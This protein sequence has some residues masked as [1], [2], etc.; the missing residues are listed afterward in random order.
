MVIPYGR[1]AEFEQGGTM[2]QRG[3]RT[4]GL[5]K[6][7]ELNDP[8]VNGFSPLASITT[9]LFVTC[10]TVLGITHTTSMIQTFPK[11]PTG[12]TIGWNLLTEYAISSELPPVLLGA[13]RGVAA[14]AM[15]VATLSSRSWRE[16]RESSVRPGVPT[17]KKA[18]GRPLRADQRHVTASSALGTG[19]LSRGLLRCA[20][21]TSRAAQ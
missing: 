12:V 10:M 11:P 17:H 3:R 8:T 19:M 16:V 5:T 2:L 20:H 13:E 6:R 4:D 18:A 9:N 7:P 14:L 21:G 15:T 1:R